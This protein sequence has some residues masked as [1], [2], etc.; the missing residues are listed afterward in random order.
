MRLFIFPP[1]ARVLAIL[2]LKDYLDIECEIVPIDLSKGDQ[3]TPEYA[4]RNPNQKM[5]MLEDN[6]F[7]LWESNAILFYLANNKPQS[8]LWPSDLKG[9]ADVLRWLTWE[10]AHWD[11]ESL[12]MVAYETMSKRVLG[13]G[14]PDSSFIAR[15]QQNFGRFATVLNESLKRRAWLTGNAL[16]IADFSIAGLVPSA[17]R[18][19]LPVKQFPEVVRWYAALAALPAWHRALEVKNASMAAWQASHANNAKPELTLK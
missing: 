15:G 3:R 19:Q 1:S 7:V 2:A 16:T 8:G 13:L 5:P 18:M 4:A 10:S 12:G 17:E 9:Q 11:A 6:D 14:P